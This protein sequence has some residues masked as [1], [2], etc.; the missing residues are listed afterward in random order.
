MFA[1]EPP[2][3]VAPSEASDQSDVI[4]IVGTRA[5]EALK[6]DRRT[7]QVQQNPHSAQKDTLQLLRGLP[8][9]TITP[10]D[11]INLLG[12][13]NVKILIDGHETRTDLRSLHGSDIDRIEIITNPSAQYSAEG[14]GG[15]INIVLRKKQGEGWSGN[16]SLEA[17]TYGRMRPD[18]TAKYKKGKW[19]YEIASGGGAGAWGHSTYRKLRSV[20]AVEGGP[21]MVN[22]EEGGGPA[23]DYGG[24]LRLKASYELDSK[25]NVSAE[26]I[27]GGET[28]NSIN[29]ARF[30][31][32][33]PDFQSFSQ[34]QKESGDAVYLIGILALDHKGS[35]DGETLKASS[36]TFG[37]PNSRQTTAAELSDGTSFRSDRRVDTFFS[38]NK[39]DW[40][41]PI[42]KMQILSLGGEWELQKLSQHYRFTSPDAVFGPDIFDTFSGTQSTISAYTT[43]QQSIGSW[44]VI[45]G[46]SNGAEQQ[47]NL[48][49]RIAG[50]QDRAHRPFPHASRRTSVRQELGPDAQLQ[51]AHRPSADRPVAPLSGPVGRPHD[52]PREPAAP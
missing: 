15:I 17:S 24:N 49:P 6:I 47:A 45:A 5:K 1:S 52:H 33:T 27:G 18:A 12:A 13:A 44:T 43:F 2:A 30:I 36:T 38:Q 50:R 3:V 39:I 14:T 29:R 26:A 25:T 7:Y 21:A 10:D 9:V 11:Q 37:N 32:V 20:E 51:Q 23:R 31:G 22:R 16:G 42:G 4:E 19:T 34:R 48:E 46:R 41:H 28:Y 40:Q 35:R 8:A